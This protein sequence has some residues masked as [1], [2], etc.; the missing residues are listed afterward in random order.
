MIP[1]INFLQEYREKTCKLD[2][3][4]RQSDELYEI[5]RDYFEFTRKSG[6]PTIGSPVLK[7]Q[8]E[9]LTLVYSVMQHRTNCELYESLLEGNEADNGLW[10]QL[11]SLFEITNVLSIRYH[12][13]FSKW[14]VIRDQQAKKIVWLNKA[15]IPVSA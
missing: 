2:D 11:N 9:V 5:L 15:K 4:S 13:V 12:D 1:E 8:N 14:E 6:L 10:S 7:L 3:L